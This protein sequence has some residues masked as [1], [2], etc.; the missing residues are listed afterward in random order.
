MVGALHGAVDRPADAQIGLHRLDLADIAERLQM[1]GELGAARRDADAVAALGQRPDDMP[2]EKARAAKNGHQ[3]RGLQDLGHDGLRW[4]LSGAGFQRVLSR[5]CGE[6][7]VHPA[8][9]AAM[10]RAAA[11]AAA[12][13]VRPAALGDAVARAARGPPAGCQPGRLRPARAPSP[14]R[15]PEC[16]RRSRSAAAPA[17][18]SCG[19]AKPGSMSF[20]SSA[21]TNRPVPGFCDPCAKLGAS[22]DQLAPETPAA[23]TSTISAILAPRSPPKASSAPFMASRRIGRRVALGI[24]RPAFGDLVALARRL[25]DRGEGCGARRLV[26]EQRRAVGD[27][28]GEGHRVGAVDRLR[29]AGAGE[30]RRP[31]GGGDGNQ[32]GL[33]EAGGEIAE[34]AAGIGVL[35]REDGDAEQ[36]GGLGEI[37][38][39]AVEGRYRPNRAI[40]SAR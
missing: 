37:V 4:R 14:C 2:A 31:V 25:A 32:S 39:A 6:R 15:V 9:A 21:S 20:G 11:A 38:E 40:A 35:L 29:R 34:R 7:K 26:D 24:H 16:G 8:G 22:S 23:S 36:A 27:R 33:R 30:Q 10:R 5:F 17:G 28:C 18:P 12:L 19:A 1:A 13:A 3:F